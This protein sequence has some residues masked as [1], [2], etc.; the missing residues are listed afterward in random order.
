MILLHLGKSNEDIEIKSYDEISYVDNNC[1]SSI[2]AITLSESCNDLQSLYDR[3]SASKDDIT[4][5]ALAD[6]SGSANIID[7]SSVYEFDSVSA[8]YTNRSI[9]V[10]L[11]FYAKEEL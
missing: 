2:L 9:L 11:A 7:V 8:V 5:N 10:T 1:D 4:V 6:S 3:I